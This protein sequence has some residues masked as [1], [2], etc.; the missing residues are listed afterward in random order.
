MYVCVSVCLCVCVLV[1]MFTEKRK[2]KLSKQPNTT[3]HK[4]KDNAKAEVFNQKQA[5]S[6]DGGGDGKLIQCL[7]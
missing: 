7:P 2:I 5:K 3:L 4:K 1:R 6:R